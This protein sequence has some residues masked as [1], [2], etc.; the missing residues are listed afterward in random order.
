MP[1]RIDL[2]KLERRFVLFRKSGRSNTFLDL[3]ASPVIFGCYGAY[4]PRVH[5]AS[6][7]DIDVDRLICLKAR[8]LN[9][10]LIAF[11]AAGSLEAA[12]LSLLLIKVLPTFYLQK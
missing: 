3:C 11:A 6:R 7:E 2:L 1:E 8:K 12:K 4:I 10:S 9:A 5:A